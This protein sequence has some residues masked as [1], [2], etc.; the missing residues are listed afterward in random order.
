MNVSQ[1]VIEPELYSAPMKLA[2][3]VKVMSAT[4]RVDSLSAALAVSWNGA[5]SPVNSASVG[6]GMA[7]SPGGAPVS[8]HS[9]SYCSWS[10]TQSS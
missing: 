10:A 1:L 7:H 9:C 3:I 4:S 6:S 8:R 5:E 2:A